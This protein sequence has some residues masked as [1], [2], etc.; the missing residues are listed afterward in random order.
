VLQY[1]LPQCIK[2]LPHLCKHHQ[3]ITKHPQSSHILSSS[4]SI[5]SAFGLDPNLDPPSSSHTATAQIQST[6]RNQAKMYAL[7]AITIAAMAFAALAAADCNRTGQKASEETQAAMRSE[8][9]INPVCGAL[10]GNY[11]SGERRR[12]CVDIGGNK[13]DF[14]LHL[15]SSN[16]RAIDFE[17]CKNGMRK[18]IDC[19]RGGMTKYGNWEYQYAESLKSSNSRNIFADLSD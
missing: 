13:Y 3:T 9:R 18:E 6:V 15:V 19:E 16:A 17:E 12:T 8:E 10:M 11:A 5:L 2:T 1:L 4:T 14:M 7:K